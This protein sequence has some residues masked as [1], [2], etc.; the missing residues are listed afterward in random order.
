MKRFDSCKITLVLAL[1]VVS[2]MIT[3]GKG[4]V[5]FIFG[6]PSNLGT[7]IAA[8]SDYVPCLPGS[9]GDLRT[10]SPSELTVTVNTKDRRQTIHN[11]GASDAWSI[12][13]VGR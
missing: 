7:T 9:G 5:D 6:I 11:F 1:L 2:L 4:A 10:S 13:F 12:Q 8:A 3:D